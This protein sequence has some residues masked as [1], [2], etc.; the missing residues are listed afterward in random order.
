MAN[1]KRSLSSRS[2]ESTER[3]GTSVPPSGISTA[4]NTLSAA[5]SKTAPIAN[6]AV[7]TASTIPPTVAGVLNAAE[8]KPASIQAPVQAVAIPA[9]PVMVSVAKENPRVQEMLS[10]LRDPVAEVARDAATELGRLNDRSAVE[11]L[12][13]VLANVDG[14]FH[15]VVR[16]A[17]A[18]SLGELRDER[19]V[20]VLI[21]AVRDPMAEISAEAALA[22]GNVGGEQA[23][24]ALIPVIE[25]ANGFFLALSRRAA[26][27]AISNKL[28]PS[29]RDLLERI[30]N[31]DFEDM[32][33]QQAAREALA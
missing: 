15:L 13:G 6:E 30:A 28:T 5:V 29:H 18:G 19:A 8:K 27:K 23:I 1:K 3:R 21:D 33:V 2:S 16:C 25:N 4:A 31:S 17:A 9:A 24:N 22:L 7:K 20:P 12:I 14:Y 32:T 11:S 26:I 10:Q